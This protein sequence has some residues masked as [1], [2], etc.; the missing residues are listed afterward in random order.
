MSRISVALLFLVLGATGARAQMEPAPGQRPFEMVSGI[1][2]YCAIAPGFAWTREACEKLTVEFSKRAE[3]LKLP[4]AE[5]PITA[6][7][8]TRKMP[9]VG[10]FDQDKA[11]RVF[12]Y[13]ADQKDFP[14]MVRGTLSSTRIWEPTA[15][16]IP[17]VAPGQR[18]SVPFWIQAASFNRGVGYRDAAKYLQ[19]ITDSFFL[20]GDKK[21]PSN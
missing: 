21:R 9:T 6:D 5:V 11:V 2:F 17:N 13:F 1:V 12:W 8:S 10:G 4:F 16:E 7:F 14:G 18:I 20:V 3:A 19:L 15:K